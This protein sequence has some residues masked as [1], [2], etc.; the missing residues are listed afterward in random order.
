MLEN[1]SKNLLDCELQ[2]IP[3]GRWLYG[4]EH[5][6]NTCSINKWVQMCCLKNTYL[7]AIHW[8]FYQHQRLWNLFLLLLLAYIPRKAVSICR[9]QPFFQRCDFSK[10]YKDFQRRWPTKLYFIIP[11]V[12]QPPKEL[13][14]GEQTETSHPVLTT[15]LQPDS[16]WI[17]REREKYRRPNCRCTCVSWI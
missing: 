12:I 11:E 16:Q 2:R 5:S 6:I 3:V 15:G 8:K 10:A 1:N 13:H 14:S 9:E 7:V 17:H 4:K